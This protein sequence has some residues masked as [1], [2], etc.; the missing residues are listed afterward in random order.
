MGQPQEGCLLCGSIC[1]LRPQAG[2]GAA[3]LSALT[4]KSGRW[5]MGLLKHD[6]RRSTQSSTQR[7]VKKASKS[8]RQAPR[9][10]VPE[11]EVAAEATEPDA[12]SR[13]KRGRQP[14]GAEANPTSVPTTVASHLSS[15]QR[16]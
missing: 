11:R 8:S 13:D 4:D 7:A 10:I 3:A 15:E 12:P 14:A 6:D 16:G 2:V 9:T 5:D 1:R